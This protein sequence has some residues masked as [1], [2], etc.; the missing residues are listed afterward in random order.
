M[1]KQDETPTFGYE[2]T[3]AEM[4]NVILDWVKATEEF[5]RRYSQL[6]EVINALQ[7]SARRQPTANRT[8][9]RTL[10]ALRQHMS[11]VLMTL[12]LDMTGQKPG[13]SAQPSKPGQLQSHARLLEELNRKI[14]KELMRFT[15][16][17]A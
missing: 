17:Q 5:H 7:A 16:A 13:R 10:T 4:Q 12:L 6:T 9:L 14:D 2:A 3:P 15:T 11:D 1:M 8:R